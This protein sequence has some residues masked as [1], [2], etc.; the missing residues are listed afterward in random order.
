[1]YIYITLNRMSMPRIKCHERIGLNGEL[2]QTFKKLHK[3]LKTRDKL[4]LS[5][6][7]KKGVCISYPISIIYTG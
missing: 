1:M 6:T 3:V 5:I 2:F 7:T 4:L